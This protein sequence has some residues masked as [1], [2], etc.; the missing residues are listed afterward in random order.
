M[1]EGRIRIV[2]EKVNCK[3]YLYAPG[4]QSEAKKPD[5]INDRAMREK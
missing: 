2:N 5:R 1:P 3:Y 4:I